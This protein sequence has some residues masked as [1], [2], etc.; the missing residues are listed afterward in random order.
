MAAIDNGVVFQTD[1]RGLKGYP[2]E[3]TLFG[4]PLEL[5][6]FALT[7]ACYILGADLLNG[8][9]RQAQVFGG[10]SGQFVQVIGRKKGLISAV[11]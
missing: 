5:D 1:I 3:R 6:L 4:T 2:A 7:T 11:C 9:G 8:I 10:A